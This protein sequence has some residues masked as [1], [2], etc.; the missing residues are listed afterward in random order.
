[1]NNQLL[2]T[3]FDFIKVENFYSSYELF[4]GLFKQEKEDLFKQFIIFLIMEE[5]TKKGFKIRFEND[6]KN[7][8]FS[9]EFIF[10]IEHFNLIEALSEE[11][12]FYL[13]NK[14]FISLHHFEDK[15]IDH[16][17]LKWSNLISD[18]FFNKQQKEY[19]EKIHLESIISN[20]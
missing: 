5:K 8:Y 15:K 9:L 10:F 3:F 12:I 20:F 2:N 17:L 4:C 11:Q 16:I 19:I 1:M 14:Y 18:S 6:L 7:T 13:F